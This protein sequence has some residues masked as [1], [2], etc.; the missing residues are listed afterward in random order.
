M[1]DLEK[2]KPIL[3]PV[4]TGDN[5]A[6]I[7]AAI[8]ALDEE[9]PTQRAIDELNASWNKKFMDCFFG[10]NQAADPEPVPEPEEDTEP[11]EKTEYEDLFKE[12]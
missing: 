2:L 6:E 11:E 12:D 4:L 5:A 3:E 8:A 10:K 7:I 9:V 1:I